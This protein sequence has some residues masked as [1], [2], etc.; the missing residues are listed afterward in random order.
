MTMVK[1]LLPSVWRKNDNILRRAQESPFLS[2]QREMNKLFS[3]FF[4]DFSPAAFGRFPD[5][6]FEPSI[7]VW[8]DEKK[9]NVRAELPGLDDKDIEVNLTPDMLIIR[10][11]KK[12]QKED[13]DDG[14][15]Y[16]EASYGSFQ[17]SIPLPEGIDQ[18]KVE[19]QFKNGVLNITLPRLEGSRTGKKITIKTS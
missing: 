3:N 9:I 16:K 12:E 1:N 18:Q 2:L 4:E 13:Q 5:F 14:Y 11:E 10:G 19:A 6:G 17:R 15:W 8:E 7:D